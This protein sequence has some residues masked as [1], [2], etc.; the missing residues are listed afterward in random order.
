DGPHEMLTRA[1]PAVDR[2][3]A[4]AELSCDRADV[5]APP[6][7]I[8][9]ERQR[10]DICRARRGGSPPPRSL[11][12]WLATDREVSRSDLC[13]HSEHTVIAPD[14][15]GH[16]ESGASAGDYSLGAMVATIR[17]ILI[18]LGHERATVIGHSL[19]DGVAM[20]FSYLFPDYTERLVL[21][22]SGALGRSVNPA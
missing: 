2:R 13:L 6:A 3:A 7:Q 11:A 19:G 4:D 8:A 20:H 17:D 12:S 14:L 9:V 5:D 16:G 1:E 15:P 21:I 18:A 22:S 10:E